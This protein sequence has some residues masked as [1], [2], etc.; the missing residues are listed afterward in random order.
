[1]TSTETEFICKKAKITAQNGVNEFL[2]VVEKASLQQFLTNN[3]INIVCKHS[4]VND[5]N[6][7]MFKLEMMDEAIK[8]AIKV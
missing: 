1:M 6:G 7:I 2:E 8:A 4:E 3:L 5:L